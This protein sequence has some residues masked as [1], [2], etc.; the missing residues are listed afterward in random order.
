MSHLE[1]PSIGKEIEKIEQQDPQ[2]RILHLEKEM[3]EAFTQ[4]S[5]NAWPP[6]E[7]ALYEILKKEYDE[8]KASE[9]QEYKKAA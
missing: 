2:E 8:L 7:R 9:A 4:G 5:L 3:K 1:E 6:E